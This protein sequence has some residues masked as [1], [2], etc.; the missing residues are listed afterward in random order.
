MNSQ[1]GRIMDRNSCRSPWQNRM[2]VSVRQ[3]LPKIRGQALTVQL[4]IFNFL[5]LLNNDWGRV[6]LPV[7]SSA[8]P[9]Q[10]VLIQRGA[11]AGTL[12]T[13]Q[14]NYEFDSQVRNNGGENIA[15]PFS[16]PSNSIGNLY[17]MQ[18][19]FRWAF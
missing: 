4:D 19:T 5:N 11:T 12:G 8:F 3:S 18:L 13:R 6:R 15:E 9:S 7:L 2:D 10:Q 14:I 1:R 17:R 16:V